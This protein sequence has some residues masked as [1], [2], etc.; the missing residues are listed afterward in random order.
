LK[1]LFLLHK[2]MVLQSNL[3]FARWQQSMSP[4]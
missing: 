4:D 1:A 3:M 2:M